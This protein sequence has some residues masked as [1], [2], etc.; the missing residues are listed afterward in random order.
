VAV[1]KA[2]AEEKPVV[3]TNNPQ[4]VVDSIPLFLECIISSF[5]FA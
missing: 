1:V 4:V 2:A 3:E 5:A